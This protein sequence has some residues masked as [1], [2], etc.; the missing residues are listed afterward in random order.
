MMSPRGIKGI[1]SLPTCRAFKLGKKKIRQGTLFRTSTAGP[2]FLRSPPTLRTAQRLE[3]CLWSSWCALSCGF[4]LIQVRVRMGGFLQQIIILGFMRAFI[5]FNKNPRSTD[6]EWNSHSNSYRG[7]ATY[8][9]ARI[10]NQTIRRKMKQ[11][12]ILENPQVTMLSRTT[13]TKAP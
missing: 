5:W 10:S 12:Y 7:I 1:I 3:S 8:V 13:S 4:R 2:H 9:R 6:R 11:N